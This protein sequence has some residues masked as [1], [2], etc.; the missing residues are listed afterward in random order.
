VT[1]LL[2]RLIVTA[3]I[4]IAALNVLPLYGQLTADAKID[5]ALQKQLGDGSPAYSVRVDMDF[6][7]EYFHIRKLQAIGTVA[8]V[9]GD[10][11]RVLQL[12]PDEVHQIARFY[13][14]KK[15]EPLDNTS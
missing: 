5:P 4:V 13:W 10:T 7:P 3:L 2:A 8:G 9:Q 1:R 15:V 14:V 12:T 11:V 6:P